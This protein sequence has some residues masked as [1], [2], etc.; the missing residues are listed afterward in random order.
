MPATQPVCSGLIERIGTP[1]ATVTH[2]IYADGKEEI[3]NRV[4]KA[5][6]HEQGMLAAA[7]LLTDPTNGVIRNADEIDVVGHRIVHGGEKMTC[8]VVIDEDVKAEIQRLF[9]LAP[10]HNP[11]SYQG[12][13][14]AENL[15]KKAKQVAVFDTAFHQT[16]PEKAFRYAIPNQFYNDYGIRVYGFHGISHKYVSAV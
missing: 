4:L 16:L 10:L 13:I 8:P 5:P 7:K 12:I 2:K 11:G 15:F 3:I 9:S 6:D 14:V 1:D